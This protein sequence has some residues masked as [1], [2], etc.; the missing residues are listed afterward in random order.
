MPRFL[1]SS[2]EN[3]LLTVLGVR[4]VVNKRKHVD[5]A[6]EDVTIVIRSTPQGREECIIEPRPKRIKMSAARPMQIHN[7]PFEERAFDSKGNRLPWALE[8]PESVAVDPIPSTLSDCSTGDIQMRG[9]RSVTLKR[10]VHLVERIS[11][12]DRLEPEQRRRPRKKTLLWT[13]SRRLGATIS[14]SKPNRPRTPLFPHDLRT[15]RH[16]LKKSL[17]KCSCTDI[18]LADNGRR[19]IPMRRAVVEA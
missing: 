15:M 11:E 16:S 17:L 18:P 9:V 8:W 6:F 3:G 13:A 2:K 5:A 14:G 10:K 7:V 19:L 1:C 4:R 12:K